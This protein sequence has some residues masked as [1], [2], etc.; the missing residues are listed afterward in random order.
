[1]V[2]VWCGEDSLLDSGLYH[3]RRADVLLRVIKKVKEEEK[4]RAHCPVNTI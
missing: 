1:M 2:V 3:T 4:K